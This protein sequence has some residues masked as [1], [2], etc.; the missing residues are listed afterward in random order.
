MRVKI[1]LDT[2]KEVQHFVDAAQQVLEPVYIS[3]GHGLRVSAKSLLGAIYA[4]E[5]DE[6]CCETKNDIQFL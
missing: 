5:F 4:L 2:M 1:H 3:D 6:L